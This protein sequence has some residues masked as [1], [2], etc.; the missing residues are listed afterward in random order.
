MKKNSKFFSESVC[1]NQ[2]SCIFAADFQAQVVKLVD[3]PL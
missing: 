3:T 2:K 1:M